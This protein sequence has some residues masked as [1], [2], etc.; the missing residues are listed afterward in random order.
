MQISQ[1]RNYNISTKQNLKK[2]NVIFQQAPID[3]TLKTV[4]NNPNSKKVFIK[5]AEVIGLSTIIAWVSHLTKNRC[6]F[7]RHL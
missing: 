1:I 4:M 6:L 3:K 2:N 5:L 7:S